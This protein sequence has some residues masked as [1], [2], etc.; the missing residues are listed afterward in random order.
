MDK[1]KPV[2]T[3]QFKKDVEKIGRQQKNLNLLKDIMELLEKQKPIPI[4]N[5]DH[6]LKGNLKDYREL[7]I[8]PDWLLVYRI[9]DIEIFYYRTGSHSDLFK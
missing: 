6:C 8:D 9:K 2:F 3:K 5:K 1:L 7:H 4:K